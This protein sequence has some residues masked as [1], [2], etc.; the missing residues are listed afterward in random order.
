[1]MRKKK[2]NPKKKLIALH[3]LV[4]HLRDNYECQHPDC[5]ITGKY[6]HCSH[7]FPKGAYPSMQFMPDNAVLLCYHHHL[8][9]WHK[10]IIK[11]HDWARVHLGN[12]RFENLC[13]RSQKIVPMTAVFYEQTELDLKE[14]LS[15]LRGEIPL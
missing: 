5:H 14:M 12:E 4:V 8:H 3:S 2:W 15:E 13:T 9:W 7:I 11:A 6:L 1:M 10:D